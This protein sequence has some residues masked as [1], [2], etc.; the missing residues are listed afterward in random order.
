MTSVSPTLS[1]NLQKLKNLGFIEIIFQDHIIFESQSCYASLYIQLIIVQRQER[2]MS[3]NSLTNKA[4]ILRV[5]SLC[6]V[7]SAGCPRSSHS[8]SFP[9]PDTASHTSFVR[10]GFGSVLLPTVSLAPTAMPAD[11]TLKKVFFYERT[12]IAFPPIK[13]LNL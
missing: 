3:S 12:A 6:W 7:F 2:P 10:H 11:L 9:G 8:S 4:Q 13:N 5:A 1:Q